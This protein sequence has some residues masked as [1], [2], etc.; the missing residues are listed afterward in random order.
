MPGMSALLYCGSAALYH[1][2]R[3]TARSAPRSRGP[4]SPEGGGGARGVRAV[5][6]QSGA[7]RGR[8]AVR[9]ERPPRGPRESAARR[10]P[11]TADRR[12]PRG[13]RQLEGCGRTEGGRPGG[14][15]GRREEPGPHRRAALT[16]TGAARRA[17]PG[18]GAPPRPFSCPRPARMPPEQSP[19]SRPR[20]RSSLPPRP[21]PPRRQPE[22]SGPRGAGRP[23]GPGGTASAVEGRFLSLA[24]RKFKAPHA[25]DGCRLHSPLG[26]GCANC[27]CP[28]AGH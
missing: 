7:P 16:P 13:C 3:C 14:G 19:R 18:S 4:R 1:C 24:I 22:A 8:R 11:G 17:G 20:S 28:G 12:G 21:A 25:G 15:G 9:T 26:P 10:A 2:T 5:G 27:C 6:A 23:A